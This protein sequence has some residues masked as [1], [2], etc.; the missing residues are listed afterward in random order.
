MPVD[1]LVTKCQTERNLR[2][3]LIQPFHLIQEYWEDSMLST[4][5][6]LI[7][8]YQYRASLALPLRVKVV[9]TTSPNTLTSLAIVSCG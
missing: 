9:S 3:D 7:T 4:S 5:P 6:T 2:E 8:S 1:D